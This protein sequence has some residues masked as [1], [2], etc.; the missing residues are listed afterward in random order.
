MVLVGIFSTVVATSTITVLTDSTIVATA[1]SWDARQSTVNDDNEDKGIVL[2][3]CHSTSIAYI[4]SWFSSLS[5][6][7]A[8]SADNDDGT[9]SA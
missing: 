3:D 9:I 4:D 1:D 7:A 2:N 5:E 6:A 8:A